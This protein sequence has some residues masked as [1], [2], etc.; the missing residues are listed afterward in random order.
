MIISLGQM[1]KGETAV[2]ISLEGGE[3]FVSRLCNLGVRPGVK[4]TK[5]NA[6]FW[7]GPVTIKVGASSIALGFGM[8]GRIMVEVNR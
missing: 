2:V 8:A 7:R 4:I 5:L 3:N 1:K 6:H